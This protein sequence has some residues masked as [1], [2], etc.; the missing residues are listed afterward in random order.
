VIVDSADS[1]EVWGGFRVA[2]RARVIECDARVAEGEVS[3]AGAHDGY[4]RLP[5]RNIHRRRW[6]LRDG[7]LDIEDE[8]G[9]HRQTAVAW[10]HL[11][12][13]V[14]ARQTGAATVGLDWRGGAASIA[15]DG[16]DE[17]AIAPCTWH[18]RFGI[19][20]PNAAVSASFSG[21]RLRTRVAWTGER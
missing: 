19:S 1:S 5:G 6:V 11:H 3:V 17:V 15:F 8:I 10:L 16:A 21:P 20:V 2:R 13:C 18:P 12:P 14:A 7:S 4:R 9:G